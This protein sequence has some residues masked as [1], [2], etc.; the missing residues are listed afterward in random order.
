MP[1]FKS[2]L[3]KLSI[4]LDKLMGTNIP[5]YEINKN[6]LTDFNLKRASYHLVMLNKSYQELN[7]SISFLDYDPTPKNQQIIETI[8]SSLSSLKNH[9]EKNNFKEI[10]KIILEL[11]KL[12]SQLTYNKQ[13][14][15]PSFKIKG[16]P[17]DISDDIYADAKELERC[18]NSACYRASVILCGRILEIALH[19]KFFE[20]TKLDMLEKNPGIGL[21]TLVAKLKE[22]N[23]SLD[24][25][26]MQQIHLI[27]QVRVYSVHKKKDVFSPTKEQAQAIILYTLDIIRKLFS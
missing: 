19:R 25:A 4:S 11:K 2:S 9:L 12:E 17:A 24:P 21:G 18:F 23:V 22:K 26:I 13:S 5:V 20:T 14:P 27:N 7:N 16:L 15:L 1:D 8:K 6:V 10:E 3:Q